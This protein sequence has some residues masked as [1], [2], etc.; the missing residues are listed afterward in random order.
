MSPP[1]RSVVDDISA[2]LSNAH[3]GDVSLGDLADAAGERGFGLVFILFA[4]P[5]IVPILPPGT[6]AAVGLVFMLLGIQMLIGHRKPWLPRSWRSRPVSPKLRKLTLEKAV[7]LL[8]KLSRWSRP[9]WMLVSNAVGMRWAALCAV[10]MGL[11]MLLPLPFMNTLPALAVLCIG[12]GLLNQDGA[13]LTLGMG[14]TGCV[15]AVL[16]AAA[17]AGESIYEQLIQFLS[18]TVEGWMGG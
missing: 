5:T 13:F 11:V 1:R 15:L 14:T 18:A 8:S 12:I 2:L 17:M 9:R 6:A 16:I 10:A 7:P 4:L 3:P